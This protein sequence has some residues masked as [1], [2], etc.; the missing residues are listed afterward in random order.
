MGRPR[1]ADVHGSD[2]CGG[3]P[4]TR[5][6][7][8][9]FLAYAVVAVPAVVLFLAVVALGCALVGAALTPLLGTTTPI[10]DYQLPTLETP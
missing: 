9:G 4:V 8:W 10:T 2:C 3:V 6:K 7:V 1:F 5:D